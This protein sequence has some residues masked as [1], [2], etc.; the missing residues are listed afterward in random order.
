[1]N[2]DWTLNNFTAYRKKISR[3]LYWFLELKGLNYLWLIVTEFSQIFTLIGCF[4][5]MESFQCC[6]W[7]IF[8]EWSHLKKIIWLIFTERSHYLTLNGLFSQNGANVNKGDGNQD[9]ALHWAS[10]KN[11]VGCVRLLLQKGADVNAVDFNNDTPISWA[12]RKGSTTN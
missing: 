1:M 3:S 6:K 4:S 10:Y 9:T 2:L 12:A 8:T 11:N 5:K 7:L